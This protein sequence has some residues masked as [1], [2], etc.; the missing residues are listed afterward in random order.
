MCATNQEDLG[1]PP[2]LNEIENIAFQI[3][4]FCRTR[5][6]I[7]R[8]QLVRPFAGSRL[9][10]SPYYTGW[11]LSGP[12]FSRFQLAKS[13][14]GPELLH[15]CKGG[16]FSAVVDDIVAQDIP[17]RRGRRFHGNGKVVLGGRLPHGARRVWGR[18]APLFPRSKQDGS[19]GLIS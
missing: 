1:L 5:R 11:G 17:G 16:H 3:I 6:G 19:P 8:N 13:C 14:T 12:G 15:R 10:A 9:H 7:A 2:Q 18:R 4:D